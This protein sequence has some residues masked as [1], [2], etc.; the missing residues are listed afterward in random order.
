MAEDF[1]VLFWPVRRL[2]V[3]TPIPRREKLNKL[4]IN[5]SS[6]S[7]REMTP[8]LPKLKK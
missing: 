4:K 2:E 3:T 6:F 1:L 7:I 8:Q 5:D